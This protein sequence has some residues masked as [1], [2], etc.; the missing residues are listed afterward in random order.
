[1]A[2]LLVVLLLPCLLF[3]HAAARCPTGCTCQR[4]TGTVDCR[5]A[6]LSYIPSNLSVTTEYL[7]FT[8]NSISNVS[9]GALDALQGLQYLMLDR[10]DITYIEWDSF[11]ALTRLSE[12]HLDHNSLKDARKEMFSGLGRLSLLSLSSN[13]LETFNFLYAK[14]LDYLKILKLDRNKLTRIPAGAF[15]GLINLRYLHL[16]YN[17]VTYLEEWTFAGL[18]SLELLYLNGNRINDTSQQAFAE[19]QSIRALYLDSNNLENISF[20]VFKNIKTVHLALHLSQ[21]PWHCDCDLQRTFSKIYQVT[22]LSI[23]DYPNITCHNPTELRNVPMRSVRLCIAELVTILIITATVILATIAAIFRAANSRKR[24]LMRTRHCHQNNDPYCLD[25]PGI[26]G[27]YWCTDAQGLRC[28]TSWEKDRRGELVSF[29]RG[30]RL[31]GREGCWEDGGQG[32]GCMETC[33]QDRCNGE[34]LGYG[35]WEREPLFQV[36]NV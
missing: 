24:K 15:N 34:T 28:F 13:Q 14:D 10:N 9:R 17:Q 16:E 23:A 2:A 18:W 12:L 19:L 1:M 3:T 8:N 25:N 7:D 21:N 6:H 27:P 30:C 31:A 32:E 26:Y 29:Q 20:E 35:S 5:G 11:R 22:R 36:P 33:D 4:I